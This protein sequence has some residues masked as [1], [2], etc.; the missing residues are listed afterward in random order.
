MM[1]KQVDRK[2]FDYLQILTKFQITK[3]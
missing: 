1:L 3:N 2:F